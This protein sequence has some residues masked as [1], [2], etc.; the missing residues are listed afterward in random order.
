MSEPFVKSPFGVYSVQ[1]ILLPI[2]NIAKSARSAV[3]SYCFE[4]HFNPGF[5]KDR[6]RQLALTMPNEHRKA[7]SGNVCRVSK[8]V[9]FCL[10]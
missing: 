10:N 4:L 1:F 5:C 8:K 3:P 2:E 9:N 7:Q 6:V